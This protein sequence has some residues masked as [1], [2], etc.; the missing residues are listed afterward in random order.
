MPKPII[1]VNTK[2]AVDLIQSGASDAFLMEAFGLSSVGLRKLF[3]KLMDANEIH[4]FELDERPQSAMQPQTVNVSGILADISKKAVVNADEV[5][6]DINSGMSDTELRQK[7]RLS[8]VGLESLFK[9]LVS[10]GEIM[11]FQ[12]DGREEVRR[13]AETDY[14]EEVTLDYALPED[15]SQASGRPRQTVSGFM[16]KYKVVAAAFA[17]AIV[18]MSILAV[19][20]LIVAGFDRVPALQRSAK[21]TGSPEATRSETEKQVQEATM[22][23]EAIARE[24]NDPTKSGGIDI[25]ASYLQECLDKCKKSH[26]ATDDSE[27]AELSNCQK[28]CLHAHS[29]LFKKMRQKYHGR[30]E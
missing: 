18:G 20:F 13:R 25:G 11:Q 28:E 1:K 14:S 17:G 4:Q 15:D 7:Y 24:R 9:K 6:K 21:T 10:A 2:Q 12:L 29:E 22:I 5:V 26:D 23:L 3:K 30:P 8:P 19:R 16:Q 27:K